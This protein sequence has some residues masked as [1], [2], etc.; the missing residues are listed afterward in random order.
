[1]V[2]SNLQRSVILP[3]EKAF[4]YKMRLEALNRQG[5]RS[6]LTSD[7]LGGK[8]AGQE[9]AAIVG[10]DGGDSQTQVRRYIRLTE[11]IPLPQK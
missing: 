4:S 7:P 5:Q 3:S 8:F 6:D 2:E 11:L 9:T 10:R 1:M